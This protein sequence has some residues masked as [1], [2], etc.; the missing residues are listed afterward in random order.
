MDTLTWIAIVVTV[1]NIAGAI[2]SYQ[3]KDRWM[4]N[5]Y[6]FLSGVMSGVIYN[7]IF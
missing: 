3:D 6:M 5:F 7:Q 2:K 1:S 4:G